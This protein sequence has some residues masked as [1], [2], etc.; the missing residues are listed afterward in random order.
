MRR[1]VVTSLFDNIPADVERN[2]ATDAVRRRASL[3]V[4][5][6]RSLGRFP[7]AGWDADGVA[8][9]NPRDPKNPI[10]G[11]N[12]AFHRGTDLIRLWRNLTHFQCACQR[13]KQSTPDGG[14]HVI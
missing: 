10:D 9:T 14:D 1:S 5:R 3:L 12:V 11:L 8:H 7:R 13:A 4:R 2:T 6:N